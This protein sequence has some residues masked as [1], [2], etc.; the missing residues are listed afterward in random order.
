VDEIELELD[1]TPEQIEII[2]CEAKFGF[3]ICGRRFGKT[4]ASRLRAIKKC[5]EVRGY[6]YLFCAPSYGQVLPEYEAIA[7]H[8]DIM[9]FIKR[10]PKQPYPSINFHNGSRLSF[11]SLD[12]AHLLR[13]DGFDEIGIDEIQNV[14]EDAVFSVLMPMIADR[15]GRLRGYGQFRGI[16]NWIYKKFYLPGQDAKNTNYR[17]WCYPTSKGYSFQTPEGKAE[18]EILKSTMPR[19][20]WEQ[21]CECIPQANQQAVF[22]YDDLNAIRRGKNSGAIPGRRYVGGLDLGRVKDPSGHVIIDAGT[23]SVVHS[24]LRKLG[25]KHEVGAIYAGQLYKRYNGAPVV[26]DTTGG[27]TGG[28]ASTD[29]YVKFYRQHLTYMHPQHL[30]QAVKSGMIEALALGIEQAELSIPPENEELLRQL[31]LYEWEWKGNSLSYHGPGGHD[32]DLVI[33]LALS[34]WGL[35]MGIAGG[36]GGSPLSMLR[37]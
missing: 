6:Q 25:E 22:R 5:L 27:A 29:E 15:R 16:E 31:S 13:R 21:E 33:A 37:G 20:K 8:P 18:L 24:E 36:T 23:K 30:S 11:R 34:W 19:I 26:V 2:T 9:P 17:S 7:F 3:S 12:R 10:A 35:K 4:L 32:D 28:K 14:D 1:A